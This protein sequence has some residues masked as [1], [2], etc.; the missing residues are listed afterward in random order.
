MK[1]NNKTEI[2]GLDFLRIYKVLHQ[3]ENNNNVVRTAEL[4][5]IILHDLIQAE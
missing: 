2:Q 5:R 4:R 1:W 3:K